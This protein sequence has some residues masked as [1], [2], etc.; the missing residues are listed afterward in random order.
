MAKSSIKV[1]AKAKN[2]VVTVKALI[3]HKMET[4]LR[5]D[6]K[7]GEVIPA[8]FIQA[9][10]C[11]HNGAPVLN[12]EWGAAISKNPYLSFKFTGG[13][14]GDVVKLTWSDNT[15]KTDSLETKVK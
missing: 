14:S 11:E 9:V 10:D 8:H 5:K 1:R 6:K 15:G 3:S 7:T 13:K 2:G 12:A 4:G